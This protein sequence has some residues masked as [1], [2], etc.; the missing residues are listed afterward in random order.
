[1][2]YENLSQ[3][4]S[5]LAAARGDEPAD[6]VLRNG[7]VVDVFTGQIIRRDVAISRGR[8]AGIGEYEGREEIDLGGA[9]LAPGL[10]EG[11]IHIESS[12]L[13][14]PRFAEAV[15]R[16]G[17]TTVIAD[18]HE[19]ANVWGIEG[20]RYMIRRSRQTPLDFF[21]ML[22]SC[23]PATGMETAGASLSA[24]DLE[25]LLAEEA[26]L[27]VGELMNFPGAIFGDKAVLQKAALG[28]GGKRPV[29]GH[30]PRVTG[31]ALAAY[32]AAGPSTDHECSG[33]EEACEKLSLG[34]RV[35]IREGSTARNLKDLLPLVTTVNERRFLLVSDDCRPG[36]LVQQG[37]LDNSLRLATAQG[38]DSISAIRMT[39]LNV[40]ETFGLHDRG[41]IRPGWLADLVAF[42]NLSDFRA[43]RVWKSGVLVAEDG[44][45]LQIPVPEKLTT[46]ASL[47]IP[48]LSEESFRVF[49]FNTPVR[50]IGVV[51][52]QI[53]TENLALRLMSSAG[54]LQADPTN[55]IAKIAVIE[56]HSGSGRIGLGFV[57]GLGLKEGALASTVAHDSHNLIVAGVDDRSMLTAA[58]A[59]IKCGGG[60]T[61]VR[62]DQILSQFDLPIAGLMCDLDASEAARLDD[63]LI[64]QA[65]TLG[66]RI[67]DPFMALSFLALP[68]IPSLKLTDYGLVDVGLFKHVPLHIQ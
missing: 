61:A 55:D 7:A 58:R 60:Q 53:V 46:T 66:C 4:R 6:L 39:T 40:A 49:D 42:D 52:D 11:H 8:I 41:G 36:D 12:K 21:F 63:E 35:M 3:W 68:V 28:R 15:V 43:V 16:R 1:V 31:K 30:A 64:A 48:P 57:K 34:M 33:V 5:L 56:R 14:P 24:E 25:S 62:G 22:P 51:E 2:I 20:V 47:P 17:T 50:V 65:A 59:L 45:S 37:H 26:V 44:K 18:P 10:I 13:T 29:D 32:I 54:R 38:L 9:Y 23:V 67:A 19:I 27:G